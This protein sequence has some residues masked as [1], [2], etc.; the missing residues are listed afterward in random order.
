MNKR[1]TTAIVICSALAFA[2]GSGWYGSDPKLFDADESTFPTSPDA[3]N[4]YRGVLRYGTDAGLLYINKGGNTGW[5]AIGAASMQD[6]IVSDG[7]GLAADIVT[8]AGSLL[9]DLSVS[10]SATLFDVR[11]G[12]NTGSEVSKFTVLG[13]GD[14]NSAT[15]VWK[16]G[17]G[18]EIGQNTMQMRTTLNYNQLGCCGAFFTVGTAD[19]DI[20]RLATTGQLSIG[21]AI[22]LH[23]DATAGSGDY[24]QIRQTATSQGLLT[25]TGQ[26]GLDITLNGDGMLLTGSN[27]GP[28]AGGALSA[29]IYSAS[30]GETTAVLVNNGRA[31]GNVPPPVVWKIGS[32]AAN[33]T[34]AGTEKMLSVRT[35][36]SYTNNTSDFEKAYIDSSG[37]V[38]TINKFVSTQNDAGIAVQIPAGSKLDFGNGTVAFLRAQNPNTIDTTGTIQAAKLIS[39]T[40]GVAVT[41]ATSVASFDNNP[42]AGQIQCD[43][44]RRNFGNSTGNNTCFVYD[45]QQQHAIGSA[46]QWGEQKKTFAAESAFIENNVPCFTPRINVTNSTGT[47][48]TLTCWD[49]G[50]T[51]TGVVIAHHGGRNFR[52]ATT[53]GVVLGDAYVISSLNTWPPMLPKMCGWVY[54]P[55]VVSAFGEGQYIFGLSDLGGFV[56]VAGAYLAGPHAGTAVWDLVT[57]F[58]GG[59]STTSTGIQV[60]PGTSYLLCVD[61]SEYTLNGTVGAWVQAEGD[62]GVYVTSTTNLPGQSQYLGTEIG[63]ISLLSDA[64][65]VQMGVSGFSVEMLP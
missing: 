58:D 39:T 48:S 22:Q 61:F 51:N 55:P 27:G 7:G 29:A 54:I 17:R 28:Q 53:E 10:T 4:Q 24:F 64:G 23:A 63:V 56:P 18:A 47:D 41:T 2:G 21:S 45:G 65:V 46:L 37:V 19:K 5:V 33:S 44:N 11:T 12:I 14:F 30:P 35:G 42:S 40:R 16:T 50:L 49:K 15:A 32:N 59:T 60:V 57:K 34:F 31:T 26:N 36:M 6:R 1:L 8:R 25:L 62:A 9:P 52:M 3:G 43:F 13:N 20:F 38:S